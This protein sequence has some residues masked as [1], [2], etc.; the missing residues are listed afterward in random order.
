MGMIIA[1][2]MCARKTRLYSTRY[3][4]SLVQRDPFRSVISAVN[5][6]RK[7][8]SASSAKRTMFVCLLV[9]P[10]LIS[11]LTTPSG[12]ATASAT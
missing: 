4:T 10:V 5:T 12:V 11:L 3:R 1:N 2:L 6:W 9:S 8:F 7:N